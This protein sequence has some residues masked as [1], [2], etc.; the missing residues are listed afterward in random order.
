MRQSHTNGIKLLT[1]IA[2][3]MC[4]AVLAA[5]ALAQSEHDAM[6]APEPAAIEARGDERSTPPPP[7]VQVD[8]T[9][10]GVRIY[11]Y[12]DDGDSSTAVYYIVNPALES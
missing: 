3:A 10:E 2:V 11:Q 9:D 4:A 5:P 7:Q 6:N 12:A 1:T 8:M